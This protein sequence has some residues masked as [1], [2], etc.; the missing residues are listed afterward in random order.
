MVNKMKN[1][2][3]N[4]VCAAVYDTLG[5][6]K[7]DIENNADRG[8]LEIK[9]LNSVIIETY[10]AAVKNMTTS[11]IALFMADVLLMARSE[12]V[13]SNANLPVVLM[14]EMLREELG[15]RI[16]DVTLGDWGV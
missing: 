9:W 2:K 6:L 15:P 4:E 8:S 1:M 13:G 11:E 3:F 12:R 14:I 5:D 10:R 7:K 16:I